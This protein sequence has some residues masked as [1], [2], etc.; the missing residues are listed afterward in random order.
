MFSVDSYSALFCTC[1]NLI[2]MF[3]VGPQS[4]IYLTCVLD[5][6]LYTMLAIYSITMPR[7]MFNICSYIN[8]C[9]DWLLL[10]DLYKIYYKKSNEPETLKQK[11]TQG[12]SDVVFKKNLEHKEEPQMTMSFYH[13]SIKCQSYDLYIY[14]Q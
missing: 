9:E 10:Y 12:I 7:D 11:I 14:H 6:R 5:Y 13:Q 8:S 3:Y 1:R 4:T 2:I